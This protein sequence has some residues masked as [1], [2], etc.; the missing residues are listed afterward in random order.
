MNSTLLHCL[1]EFR[2]IIY[3]TSPLPFFPKLEGHFLLGTILRKEHANA[4]VDVKAILTSDRKQRPRLHWVFFCAFT[5][6][7]KGIARRQISIIGN[8]RIS[9]FVAAKLHVCCKSWIICLQPV[10]STRIRTEKKFC[11]GF[12]VTLH[13]I[14]SQRG[15]QAGFRRWRRWRNVVWIICITLIKAQLQISVTYFCSIGLY[16]LV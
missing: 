3:R 11:W 6:D 5:H 15:N 16:F 14:W 13:S 7:E 8:D 4:F 9:I 1:F 2:I 10:F 12:P